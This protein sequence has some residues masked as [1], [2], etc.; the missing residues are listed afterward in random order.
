MEEPE[1]ED[2]KVEETQIKV[3]ETEIKKEE[4]LPEPKKEKSR[5]PL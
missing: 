3:E 4:I 1:I 5:P 2:E